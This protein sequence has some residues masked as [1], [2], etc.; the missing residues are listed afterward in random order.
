MLLMFA[1]VQ[2]LAKETGLKM[3]RGRH[4]GV[5]FQ[6]NLLEELASSTLRLVSMRDAVQLFGGK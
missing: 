1:L 4:F 6:K 3:F 2:H 5:Y